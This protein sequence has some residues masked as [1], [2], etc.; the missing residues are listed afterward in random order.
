ME[1]NTPSEA[2]KETEYTPQPKWNRNKLIILLLIVIVVIIGIFIFP[3]HPSSPHTTYRVPKALPK[4]AVVTLTDNGFSPK[5]ITVHSGE[6]VR[7]I[8]NSTQNKASV[9]S[10]DYPTNKKYPELNLGEFQKGSTLVHI[11]QKPGTYTY[12][13][14]FHHTWGGTIVVQ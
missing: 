8:N 6:A 1:P 14:Y 10:D 5:E 12:N 11:F 2:N 7:W 13:D 3:R 9:N 4:E